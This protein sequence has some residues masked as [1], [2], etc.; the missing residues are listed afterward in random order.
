MY[1]VSRLPKWAQDELALRD[2]RIAQLEQELAALSSKH[3][4]SNVAIRESVRSSEV[5]LPPDSKIS[6]Y[7]QHSGSQWRSSIEAYHEANGQL[8]VAS[9]TGRLV[10][11]PVASNSIRLRIV[12]G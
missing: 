10:V 4:G 3:P 6:F 2:R 7:M 1:D 9:D 12:N 11:L 8:Y 5:T